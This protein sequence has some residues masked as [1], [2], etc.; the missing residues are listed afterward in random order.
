M[1]NSGAYLVV[2]V[3]SGG[4]LLPGDD[5]NEV[6]YFPLDQLPP[7]AFLTDQTVVEM[8]KSQQ[9]GNTEQGELIQCKIN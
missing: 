6:D 3:I 4:K 7:M 9:A 5:L 1:A 2:T 8:L